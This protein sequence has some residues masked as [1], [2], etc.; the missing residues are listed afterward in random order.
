[1][2][3]S[4]EMNPGPT[5]PNRSASALEQADKRRRAASTQ[6]HGMHLAP[7]AQASAAGPLRSRPHQPAFMEASVVIVRGEDTPRNNHAEHT[8]CRGEVERRNSW[9]GL[10]E[11]DGY[12]EQ[13]NQIEIVHLRTHRILRII[14]RHITEPESLCQPPGNAITRFSPHTRTI[15]GLGMSRS[16]ASD[17]RDDD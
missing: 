5:G 3:D 15:P 10:L 7:R 14:V 1:M 8:M 11:F 13:W 9:T 2:I 6:I 4:N 17:G 16:T 12:E